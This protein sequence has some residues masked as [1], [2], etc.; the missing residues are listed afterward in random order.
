MEFRVYA[1]RSLIFTKQNRGCK[2]AM[3]TTRSYF[4]SCFR[5]RIRVSALKILKVE[6]A[7]WLCTAVM[8]FYLEIKNVISLWISVPYL[9][10]SSVN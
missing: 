5:F 4:I 8:V 1:F 3:A 6:N 7:K 2:N 9:L 10:T